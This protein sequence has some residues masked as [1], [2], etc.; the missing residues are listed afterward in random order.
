VITG[1]NIERAEAILSQTYKI[2]IGDPRIVMDR[3]RVDREAFDRFMHHHRVTMFNH[4]TGPLMDVDP[5]LEPSIMTMMLHF[6]A[7]GAISQR[8]SEGRS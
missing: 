2:G 1:E 7:V 4:N 3:A 8:A 6:F 5:R